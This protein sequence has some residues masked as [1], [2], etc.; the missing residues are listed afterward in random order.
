MNIDKRNKRFKTP[1]CAID[2]KEIEM[3]INK[4]VKQM[5]GE[6]KEI[7]EAIHLLERNAPTNK[8]L[9]SKAKSLA[10]QKFDVY[11]SAYANAWAS[12]WYKKKGGGWKALKEDTAPYADNDN[13][14]D[15]DPEEAKD[16]NKSAFKP[17]K[18]ED[19]LP[20][21]K[22]IKNGNRFSSTKLRLEYFKNLIN[23]SKELNEEI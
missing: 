22:V 12:K 10:R 7:Q 23:K 13:Y 8:K 3:P 16:M 4:T 15:S 20:I 9:W 21:E 14:V 1:P 5:I 2:N 6:A 18:L 19:D 11:P 17:E